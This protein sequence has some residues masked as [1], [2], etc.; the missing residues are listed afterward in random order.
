MRSRIWE[1]LCSYA[2]RGGQNARSYAYIHGTPI[3]IRS[4][5]HGEYHTNLK[6]RMRQAMAIENVVLL[7]ASTPSKPRNVE[8]LHIYGLSVNAHDSQL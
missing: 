5:E 8:L 6:K 1:T 3:R 7:D 4:T 2:H